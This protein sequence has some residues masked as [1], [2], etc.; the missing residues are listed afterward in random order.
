MVFFW[1]IKKK[2]KMNIF[3]QKRIFSLLFLS[4]LT[5]SGFWI[6]CEVSRSVSFDFPDYEPTLIIDGAASPQSGA[7]VQIQYNFPEEGVKGVISDLPALEVSIV[8]ESKKYWLQLDSVP[9]VE[10]G[11]RD[12]E[13]AY[14]SLSPESLPIDLEH[15][16]YLEVRDLS[17]DKVYES[18]RVALPPL[19]VIENVGIECHDMY[20]TCETIVGLGPVLQH[21]TISAISLKVRYPDSTMI[22]KNLREEVR[23]LF[24]GKLSYPNRG[25]WDQY[26]V[27]TTFRRPHHPPQDTVHLE[28]KVILH[29]AYLSP[30]IAKLKEEIENTYALGEDIFYNIR[31]FYSNFS[32]AYGVFGLYNED[33]REVVY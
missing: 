33:I 2:S 19:P 17:N 30:E 15:L 20:Q 10:E 22:D 1:E 11:V 21:E 3:L 27:S 28:R 18:T 16:Y 8:S 26:M 29:T 31:P 9:I 5:V 24:P 25:G 4:L 6:S 12:I 13:R 32:E 23:K 14:Y 7:M